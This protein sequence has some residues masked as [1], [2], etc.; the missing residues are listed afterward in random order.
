MD[1]RGVIET[2]WS[3]AVALATETA[4][5]RYLCGQFARREF[6]VSPGGCTKGYSSVL[7]ANSTG[8]IAH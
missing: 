5:P 4:L 1:E 7:L 6:P 3:A 2:Q 8:R